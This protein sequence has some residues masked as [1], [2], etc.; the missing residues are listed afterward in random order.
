MEQ[1]SKAMS[2]NLLLPSQLS[3]FLLKDLSHAL[4]FKKIRRNKW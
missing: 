4:D 1:K 2:C 3:F